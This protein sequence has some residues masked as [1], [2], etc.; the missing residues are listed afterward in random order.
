MSSFSTSYNIHRQKAFFLFDSVHLLKCIW[1]N[2]LDQSDADNTFV[3]PDVTDGSICKASLSHLRQLYASEKDN[4][5][6][7][8]PRLSYKA[9]HP[10]NLERQN[11][12]L[13]LKIFDEKTI[14]AVDTFGN[15]TGTDLSGTSKFLSIISTSLS[16]EQSAYVME[17][18]SFP[19]VR[20]HM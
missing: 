18:S 17:H 7:L 13:V 10:S 6:K 16:I 3:F 20:P 15:N 19:C 11:V 12:K 9:L 14:T 4:L 5:I 2:W 1:N 8:A